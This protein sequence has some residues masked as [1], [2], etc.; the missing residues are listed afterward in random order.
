[1][2][3][4]NLLKIFLFTQ[5]T[6]DPGKPMIKCMLFQEKNCTLNRYNVFI[7]TDY[8]DIFELKQLEPCISQL[9]INSNFDSNKVINKALKVSINMYL[10]IF[11]YI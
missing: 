1:M 8:G 5:F 4:L 2:D 10:G 9:Q 6:S 7:F 3:L 11:L